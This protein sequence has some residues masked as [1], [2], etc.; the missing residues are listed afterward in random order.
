MIDNDSYRNQTQTIPS[1]L[2]SFKL[3]IILKKKIY[4]S[5]IPNNKLD[6]QEKTHLMKDVT[7]IH[8]PVCFPRLGVGACV[9]R[10]HIPPYFILINCIKIDIVQS[11]K[12]AAASPSVVVALLRR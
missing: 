12:N 7:P 10:L 11:V 9:L 5:D 4:S 6:Y 1:H 2:P 8:L 3:L